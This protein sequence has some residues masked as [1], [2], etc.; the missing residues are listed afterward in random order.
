MTES[1]TLKGMTWSDPRGY[2]PVAAAARAYSEKH[3]H[4]TI[5]WDKRS[6]QGFESTPVDELAAAYDLMII[7]HP[8]VGSVADKGHLLPLDEHAP[9]PALA[10][11][12]NETVGKSFISYFL[13]GHQWALPVDAATQVQAHRPDLCGRVSSWA[14][15]VKKAQAG[16]VLWAMRN[17]HTLMNF[18]TLAANLGHPCA[19]TQSELLPAPIG[20]KV[21]EALMA[22]SDHVD[23]ICYDM[24]PIAILDL[25]ATEDRFHLTPLIYLYKGYANDG[26]RPNRIDFTDI[27]AIGASGPI[28]AALGGTGLAVSAKTA[29]ADVCVD[30]ALWVAGAECQTGLYSASNGQ[31]GNAVAWANPAVN[32]PVHGAYYNTRLTHEA[33][34]LRP[35]H[36][37]YMGFQQDGSDIIADALR[38][39]T[40][41]DAAMAALNARF[42]AS[43]A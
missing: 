7:D 13:S 25:M 10:A 27:P 8:H 12:A 41:P 22:V 42:A 24:D 6:L 9:A 34:W 15:V 18:Y 2:D 3:P 36:D 20:V 30:F 35:R 37:G 32:A 23:P 17:P 31:P 26:Y 11:L 19:S 38:R 39:K 14:D 29:H 40:S 5:T 21:I 33:S 4:V 43:F 16:E 1:I 28:G